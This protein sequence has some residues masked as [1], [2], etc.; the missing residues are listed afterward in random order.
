MGKIR[1]L[2]LGTTENRWTAMRFGDYVLTSYRNQ[3][4]MRAGL[5][6]VAFAHSQ[7]TLFL[8]HVLVFLSCSL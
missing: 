1:E 3:R 4:V 5:G 2:D 6:V 7:F 8:K